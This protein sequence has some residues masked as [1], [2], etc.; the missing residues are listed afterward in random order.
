[1][2]N[3]TIADA[4]GKDF[5]WTLDSIKTKARVDNGFRRMEVYV[6]LTAFREAAVPGTRPLVAR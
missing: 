1:M 5:S 6:A 2:P 3:A 4:K